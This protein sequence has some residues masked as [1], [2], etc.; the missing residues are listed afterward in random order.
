M[1][2]TLIASTEE[3]LSNDPVWL[4]RKCRMKERKMKC[5][6][7]FR[8]VWVFRNSNQR[9]ISLFSFFIVSEELLRFSVL[10]FFFTF[11]QSNNFF[12]S[13]LLALIPVSF[14]FHILI[15]FLLELV[16]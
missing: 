7:Y 15:L 11:S 9:R 13:S 12:S 16:L 3:N 1:T 2:G 6:F 5:W 8:V 10:L 14:M 4:P